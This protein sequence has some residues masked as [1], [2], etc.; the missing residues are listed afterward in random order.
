MLVLSGQ[1]GAKDEQRKI[2][3]IPSAGF[4]GNFAL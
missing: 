4:K 2:Y 3:F 1:K